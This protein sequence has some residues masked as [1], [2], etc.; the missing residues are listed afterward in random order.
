M[1]NRHTHTKSQASTNRYLY[2]HTYTGKQSNSDKWGKHGLVWLTFRT[3]IS[4]VRMCKFG[5]GACV[6]ISLCGWIISQFG[7]TM[8]NKAVC[9]CVCVCASVSACVCD[10]VMMQIT[11]FCKV[12]RVSIFFNPKGGI[13]TRLKCN[14]Q[15]TPSML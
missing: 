5:T 13:Q 15:P 11:L 3:V 2:A 10:R 12:C 8:R 6:L 1:K 4:S 7:G 9:P 14:E